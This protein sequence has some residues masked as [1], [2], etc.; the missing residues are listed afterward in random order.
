MYNTASENINQTTGYLSLGN[1][2][3]ISPTLWAEIFFYGQ[4][5]VTYGNNV[6]LPFSTTSL[7][8]GKKIFNGKGNLNLNINDIFY[9]GITRTEA[10]YGNIV[11]Y[12]K[13]KYDSRNVRLNFSYRFGN[14]KIDIKKRSAGSEEEQ[15]RNNNSY[16]SRIIY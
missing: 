15:R 8:F 16:C 4:S 13:S 6:N 12:L 1:N 10:N 9:T 5:K 3:T 7:S 2:I 11:Y 14:S